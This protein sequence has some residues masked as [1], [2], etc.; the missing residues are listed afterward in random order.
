[1]ALRGSGLLAALL[2]S[3]WLVARAQAEIYV[4]TDPR[5]TMHFS[6]APTDSIAKPYFPA[7]S[8]R[9]RGN[10]RQ[11]ML[12]NASKRRDFDPLIQEMSRRYQ[13]ELAL[14]KAVIHAES[15]FV[16]HAR[17]P[18]GAMGLM[19]LMP[20]TARRHNVWRI[21]DP[22]ENIQ[23]GVKHLRLL[24]DRYGGNLRKTVAA[25]N[26]GE[27]AVD[28]YGGVPPYRETVQYVQSVLQYRQVYLREQ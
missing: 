14:V 18:K 15:N 5:G 10:V 16:P 12:F 1:M 27:D 24:L 28:R 26:A 23:G 6:N 21:L 11:R 22:R 13:V 8:F 4:Y 25:Y 9:S 19:Q 3:L 2:A 7:E 20:Q 17:S